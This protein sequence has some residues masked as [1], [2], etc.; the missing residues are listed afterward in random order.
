[1]TNRLIIEDWLVEEEI[2]PTTSQQDPTAMQAPQT[3]PNVGNAQAIQNMNQEAPDPTDQGIPNPDEDISQDPE[4]PDMPDDMGHE[5]MD[6]ESWKNKYFKESIKGDTSALI[7]MIN[8]VRER[9]LNPYQEKFV[10]DNLNIQLIRNNANVDRAAREIRK[11]LKQQLDRNN[12]STS[13]VTHIFNTLE[14]DPI[15]NNIFIKIDGYGGSKGDLHRKYLSAL[16]GAVQVGSGANTEDIIVNENDYSIMLSTRCNSKWGN[17]ILGSWSLKEDD[18]ERY[19]ADPEL[20][21]LQEGSP[22]EKDV[23]RR[24]IVME[25]IANQFETRG[26]VVTV[27]GEDG[28]IY[29]FGWDIAGSLKAAYMD[30]KLVV[31][32]RHS[33]NSE[34]MI[35]DE[36]KIIPFIDLSIYYVRETGQQNEEGMPE[37]EELDFIER[38]NGNLFLTAELNTLK[39]AATA[40]Q[41]AIFKETPYRGNPSDL[42]VLRRCVFSAHDLL[43]RQC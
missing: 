29:T 5:K 30:G 14:S 34:A 11:L 24:R 31:K 2:P 20:K 13:V 17:V 12:P 35:T 22:E 40:L 26:F 7:D 9:D 3:D 38:R 1:M 8:Q 32:T 37:K 23:L 33:D 15:L 18:P 28:T 41:G 36:G 10:E 16:L 6:F 25:S 42:K 43:M 4:M 39:H 21:R 19:L 27:P